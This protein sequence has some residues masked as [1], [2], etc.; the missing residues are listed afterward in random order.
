MSY[1]YVFIIILLSLNN[2]KVFRGLLD[3][4]KQKE[5]RGKPSIK[6]SEAVAVDCSP[7]GGIIST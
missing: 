6:L 3:L 1:S 7:I 5:E 2:R 4:A